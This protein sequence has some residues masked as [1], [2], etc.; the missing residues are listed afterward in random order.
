ML[1]LLPAMA[2]PPE[3]PPEDAAG[4]ASSGAAGQTPAAGDSPEPAVWIFS[5]APLDL[6]VPALDATGELYHI[7]E[8]LEMASLLA[9]APVAHAVVAATGAR[10]DP[11][12]H[13]DLHLDRSVPYVGADDVKR[14]LGSQRSGPT[15]LLVD[16]GV[17]TA[18]P[19]FQAGGNLAANVAAERRGGL[20]TGVVESDVVVDTVGHGT[21]LAGII[22]GLGEALGP[23]D[24][25][26]RQFQGLYSNGRL[27]SFQADAPDGD[28]EPR[29]D[30]AAALESMDWALENR[31][32][33]DI[34]ATSFSWGRTGD[35]RPDHPLNQATLRLYLS[36]IT[37]VFSAGNLGNEGPGNLNQHCLAPWVLCVAA[38][39]LQNVRA[40]YSSYGHGGPDAAPYDHPDLTAPGHAIT[41]AHPLPGTGLDD[42]LDIIGSLL[43]SQ[44]PSPELYSDRSGTSMAA[45][46][47][48][49][50]AG[51]I[52]AANPDLSPDQVMDILVA[53]TDAMADEVHRVGAGYLNVREAYNLAVQAVGNRAAFLAG[54]EVKYAGVQSGDPQNGRDPVSHGFDAPLVGSPRLLREATEVWFADTWMAWVLAGIGVLMVLSGTRFRD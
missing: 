33:Y 43:G 19:D 40:P 13:Y 8:Q 32:R 4:V 26:Y 49:A 35:L 12:E 50:A 39:D 25:L 6:L 51:L 23:Q 2:A 46:H 34:R 24:P 36:G 31:E 18:H 1:A 17:D 47:V 21:H 52:Q 20:V 48:A 53:T 9:P 45:P 30:S 44:S 42:R 3:A 38:G 41:S 5:G 37:V 7:Y 16:T 11:N 10:L 28:D 14:A 27:A 29:V 54:Q 15:V 22:A